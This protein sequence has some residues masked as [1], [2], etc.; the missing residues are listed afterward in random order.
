VKSANSDLAAKYLE[1]VAERRLKDSEKEFEQ[2]RTGVGN[3][4]WN[5]GYLKALEGLLLTLR[6]NDSRYLYLQRIEVEEK[7]VKKLKEEFR[8]HSA[9]ELHGDYDRG[10]FAALTDY[11]LVLERAK[12]WTRIV[13]AE[14]S[15]ADA[16]GNPEQGAASTD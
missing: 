5:K 15:K 8:K 1:A 2:M 11:A 10:Y 14:E 16:E 12:P 3:S 4:E 13:K 7:S 6:S 9:S